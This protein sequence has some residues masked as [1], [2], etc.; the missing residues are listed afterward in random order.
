MENGRISILNLLIE[1]GCV[2]VPVFLYHRHH[3]SDEFVPEV[4]VVQ[5]RPM[6]VGTLVL[7]LRFYLELPSVQVVTVLEQELVRRAQTRLH[8]V[9]HN[10]AC[11][12]RAREFLDL[13]QCTI[14]M[15]QFRGKF[16]LFR[17]M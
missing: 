5:A 12:W 16:N 2:A 4:K 1:N 13:K 11:A 14:T 3:Q 8:T 10:C 17:K 6:V 9:F 15:H 7:V